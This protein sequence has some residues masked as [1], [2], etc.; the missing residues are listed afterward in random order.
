MNFCELFGIKCKTYSKKVFDLNPFHNIV[1]K[2][3]K[4]TIFVETGTNYQLKFAG[5]EN[6]LP[7]FTVENDTLYIQQN[8]RLNKQGILTNQILKIVVPSS[9][10]N[11][12][13]FNK[14]GNVDLIGLETNKLNVKCNQGKVRILKSSIKNT[15]LKTNIGNITVRGSNLN[16]GSLSVYEGEIKISSSIVNEIKITI[17][18]GDILMTDNTLN[19]GLSELYSGN[20]TLTHGVLQNNYFVKN[21]D[22]NNTVWDVKLH[23]ADLQ[24]KKGHNVMHAK[25]LA[26]GYTLKMIALDGDNIVQ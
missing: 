11:C 13:L 14:L 1:G 18:D 25:T 23:N 16:N 10:N 19:G 26:N 22:G 6:L 2:F 12:E 5:N 24:V 3:V 20:F 15:S 8:H 17:T 21:G 4:M 7:T 9:L